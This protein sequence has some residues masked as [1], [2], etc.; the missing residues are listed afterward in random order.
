EKLT[1]KN[2]ILGSVVI[3]GILLF[4]F[5]FLIPYSLSY[6]AAVEIFMVNE[7]GLPFH[8]GTLIAALILIA[9]FYAGLRY[10]RKQHYVLRNTIILC[11]PF[12]FIGVSS[13]IMLPVRRNAGTIINENS[14][15]T[16]RALLA[17]YS[18]EQHPDNPVFY[19][20]QFTD[21]F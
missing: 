12:T 11:L 13:W 16:A 10:T 4:I 17:G 19:G 7:I 9:L 14:P 1:V 8:S 3:V 5:K 18:R 20:P 21:M 15:Q 2:F 6:F